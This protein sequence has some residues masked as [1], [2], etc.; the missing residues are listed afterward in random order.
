MAS[1]VLELLH[2]KERE[3]GDTNDKE[4][5]KDDNNTGWEHCQWIVDIRVSWKKGKEEEE[6]GGEQFRPYDAILKEKTSSAKRC[7]DIP[8][9]L[10]R[11]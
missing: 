3:D 9:N 10:T 11:E 6:E 2:H 5:T 1:S 4:K 7:K 8:Q